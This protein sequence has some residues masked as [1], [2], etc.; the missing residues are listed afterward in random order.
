MSA[1]LAGTCPECETDLTTPPMI[2]GET[3]TCPECMLTLRVEHVQNGTLSLEMVEVKLR[4][5][6]Q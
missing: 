1:T 5:W 4:D 6:G 3:M 2:Q